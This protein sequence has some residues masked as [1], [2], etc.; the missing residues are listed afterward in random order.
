MPHATGTFE[1]TGMH[2]DPWHE[3]TVNRAS[4]AL[5]ARNG[6]TATSRVTVW[7]SGSPVTGTP[8]RDWSA[9]RINGTIDGRSGAFVIEATSDHDGKQSSGS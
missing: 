5:A 7:W 4:L 9:C 8:A 2:E 3:A 1:I 6:S